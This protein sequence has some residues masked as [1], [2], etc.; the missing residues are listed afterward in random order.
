M[1][2]TRKFRGRNAFMEAMAELASDRRFGKGRQSFVRIVG[3]FGGV[4]F[5][6]MLKSL[7]ADPDVDG[8]AVKAV[9]RIKLKGC[10]TLVKPLTEKPNP[11]WVRNVAK[12]YLERFGVPARPGDDSPAVER[13]PLADS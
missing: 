2:A 5:G 7:I 6:E 10:D 12:R 9:T 13:G 1:K 8:Q 3:D 11:T 4:S